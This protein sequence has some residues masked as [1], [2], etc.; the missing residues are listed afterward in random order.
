M[1]NAWSITESL[2]VYY[3]Y[4]GKRVFLANPEA[5]KF[6]GPVKKIAGTTKD[7]VIIK[8]DGLQLKFCDEKIK[9][10]ISGNW[11]ILGNTYT[12]DIVSQLD[13][14]TI[15]NGLVL[16]VLF[17]F[18]PIY[19][20]KVIPLFQGSNLYKESEKEFIRKTNLSLYSKTTK[21]IPGHKYES[22]N[23]TYIFLGE[24]KSHKTSIY[25]CTEYAVDYNARELY[26]FINDIPENLQYDDIVLN[27]NISELNSYPLDIKEKTIFLES[28]KPAMADLGELIKITGKFEDYWETKI[29]KFISEKKD[30]YSY[31]SSQYN[32][33]DIDDLINFFVISGDLIPKVSSESKKLM[34]KI[35][36]VEYRFYLFKFYDTQ[37]QSLKLNI[38]KS[39]DMSTQSDALVNNL[40][41]SGI[42]DTRNYYDKEYYTSLFKK[43]FDIDL[44]KLAS[45]SIDSFKLETISCDDF[46]DLIENFG[47][48]EFRNPQNYIMAIDFIYLNNKK[49]KFKTF[50]KED[51]YR[52]LILS[53][54]TDA[55]N[56]YG[57]DL[58][59]FNVRNVGTKR[60]PSLE[61]LFSIT[62]EDIVNYYKVPTIN[63]IPDS[64]KNDLIK[65][66]IY[67]LDI[68]TRDDIKITD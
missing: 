52:N 37:A 47:Y 13:S 28:K 59:Y 5:K 31:G 53:M 12:G 51:A 35:I 60:S 8:N 43:V 2:F 9:V 19:P 7:P 29:K 23:G 68:R 67:R 40:V 1:K 56:N 63:D 21:Y 46:K 24:V 39:Q 64:I 3:S 45:L 54:Y 33:K 41:S 22:E 6:Y 30:P 15:N 14:V 34:E 17:G 44:K 4:D 58:K 27:Y 57:S 42:R 49:R 66:K 18:N 25:N 50:L 26:A 10:C 16:D 61:Y 11:Y 55:L 62:L 36:K 65:N 20:E 32:Y 48:F 38:L